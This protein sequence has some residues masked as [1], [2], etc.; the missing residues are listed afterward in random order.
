MQVRYAAKLKELAPAGEP[1]LLITLDYDQ[2]QMAGPPFATPRS[3]V[4]NLFADRY[5][6]EELACRSALERNPQLSQRGLIME[7]R[8]RLMC[9][10]MFWHL[11]DVVWI[12]VFTFVYLLGVLR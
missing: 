12:G 9:L 11:L 10:S 3:Q 8:R 5:D 2:N 6:I 1:I 4:H 7:N